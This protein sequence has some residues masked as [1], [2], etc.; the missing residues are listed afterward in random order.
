MRVLVRRA[1]RATRPRLPTDV[2]SPATPASDCCERLSQLAPVKRKR[3][4]GT[5]VNSSSAAATPEIIVMRTVRM[6]WRFGPARDR[7]ERRA[8]RDAHEHPALA[9]AG[10]AERVRRAT[11]AQ[12]PTRT[13]D[14]RVAQ[15]H[16]VAQQPL[17]LALRGREVEH[18][19]A[20]EIPLVEAAVVHRAVRLRVA[21]LAQ[22]RVA[23]RADAG[24]S[25]ARRRSR[26]TTN[27]RF[28]ITSPGSPVS[29]LDWSNA[30]E[31]GSRSDWRVSRP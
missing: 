28:G 3:A 14:L 5:C 26:A 15:V 12:P 11:T 22:L 16:G 8:E 9:L 10:D 27:E 7:V 6:R 1:D 17:L 4:I 30:R 24:S 21:D 25:S 19:V 31:N 13:Y 18:V 2:R 20:V 29:F 23:L